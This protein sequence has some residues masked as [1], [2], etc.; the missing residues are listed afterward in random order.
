MFSLFVIVIGLLSSGSSCLAD[1]PVEHGNVAF[2]VSPR[3]NQIA[4]ASADGDLFLLQL[5]SLRVF[6]LTKTKAVESTPAFSPDGRFVTYAASDG[7]TSHIFVRSLDGKTQKQLTRSQTTYDSM[8]SFSPDGSRIVF[9]RAYLHRPYSM[10]GWTWN[11]WDVCTM[12]SDGTQQRRLTQQK[13]YTASTPRFLSKGKSV[14]YSADIS[15]GSSQT[16]LWNVDAQGARPPRNLTLEQHKPATGTTDF[17][18]SGTS[19]DVSLGGRRI[20]FISDHARPFAYDLYV[21]K[22]D[23]SRPHPLNITGISGYNEN[24]VF[25]PNGKSVLFLAGTEK[26]A[27]SRPIYSLWQV[28]VDGRGAHRIAGS[29]LFTDPLT[30]KPNKYGAS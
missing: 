23:G 25:L 29:G 27:A 14:V 21:M 24:P 13:Y 9:A 20:V 4:F 6:R 10:G 2:D 15:Q 16:G 8:P 7:D 12:K 18:T 28:G 22:A 3:G 1:K 5:K 17:F 30:W 11:D 26:N 19:P